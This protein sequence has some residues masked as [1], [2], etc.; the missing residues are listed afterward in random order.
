MNHTFIEP[1]LAAGDGTPRRRLRVFNG[2]FL[3]NRRL[4]RILDLSNFDISLGYPRDGDMIGVWGKSPTA[5][6]GEKMAQKSGVPLVRFEDAFLRSV[7]P[8]RAGGR[9]PLG[10]LIDEDGLYFDPTS[11]SRIEKILTSAPLDDGAILSRGRDA[12]GRIR[13]LHLSKYN[14]HLLDAPCPAPG[15]V[16][17]IDQA[18]NDAS[19]TASG[20]GSALFKEMLAFAQI[21]HPGAQ[22]LIKTHPETIAGFRAGYFGPEDENHRVSLFADPVSPWSLL[23]GAVGVYTVSSQFGFE[24]IMAG[25]K[26]RV[27]GQPFYAGWGLSLDENPVPRRTRT[28]TRTQLFAGAMMLAPTWYD[29]HLDRLCPI[30]D[31]I[32]ALEAEARAWRDDHAGWDAVGMRLWKR[33]HMRQIYGGYGGMRF[34]ETPRGDRPCMVW[35]NKADQAPDTAARVEDGVIRSRG[36][37]AELIPPL[38]L[39]LD[40]RG[41]YYDP[42]APSDLEDLIN[43]APNLPEGERRRTERLITRITNANLTKYNLVGDV[44]V[45]LPDDRHVILVPGQVG[46][47][48]SIT[49]GATGGVKTN[50]DLL[51]RARADN[52]DAYIIYKPHPDVVAGLR[53]G[54]VPDEVLTL[55]DRIM[56]GGDMGALLSKV[57]E[58]WTLTS[59]TGFEALLRGVPVTCLGAPF[60]AGWGLTRDLAPTPARRGA[61]PDV[62][63]LAHAVLIGYPRYFDPVMRTPAPP[64]VIMTRLEQG[65][66][67]TP[68]PFNRSL[69][70]LQG[71]FASRASLW[72]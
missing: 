16:L 3:T 25:H 5:H 40:R 41:I 7:H 20:A 66:V 31:A 51:R 15:Y 22:I 14:A 1:H 33:P 54:A 67:P 18:L 46:D 71:L 57:D 64:E 12:L 39:S 8:G 27:F 65:T 32:S 13:H 72:R 29:P 11:P 30:E 23:D 56:P 50:A 26:P 48:A 37:G 49:K 6:R 69:S 2:G 42:T 34:T 62:V 58:V 70:K 59:T 4:R 55:A 68:G 47:D 17:V 60:Y 24:A 38:S 9:G 10:I 35:A 36:L 63:A 45:D 61:R 53:D 19:V 52:P 28:L 43:A 44:A 21:E